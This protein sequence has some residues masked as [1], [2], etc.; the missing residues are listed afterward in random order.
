MFSSKNTPAIIEKKLGIPPD[1]QYKALKSRNFLKANW[2]R[3]KLVALD[4]ILKIVRPQ[5]VL[6]L[7][8]GSGNFELTFHKR[9][10]K[11]VGIDYND[12]AINFLK[13]KLKK[14]KIKNVK[15]KVCDIRDVSKIK[16]LGKF[17]LIVL[18]DVIEHLRTKDAHKLISDLKKLLIPKGKV[19]V[20]TP[21]Y[22]SPWSIIEKTLDKLTLVPHFESQQ[23]LS[24]FHNDNLAEIFVKGGFKPIF[25]RTFNL[26]SWLF[27][28]NKLSEFLVK[29]ELAQ[30]LSFGNLL[31]YLFETK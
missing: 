19:C 25:Y 14:E 30:R 10:S 6:D 22:K 3:N 21:N 11:I 1:Y 7:G 8:C 27:F 15:L 17:D 20:I 12:Q 28:P 23:H 18:T 26:F 9:V 5:R 16:N 13:D 2:H 4:Y 24:K 29:I 31:L